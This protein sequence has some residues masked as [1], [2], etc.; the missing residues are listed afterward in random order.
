MS[1]G[2]DGPVTVLA[3]SLPLETG[4]A[5]THILPGGVNTP[6]TGIPSPAWHGADT[7]NV[8]LE[9]FII[10]ANDTPATVRTEVVLMN[11]RN[12]QPLVVGGDLFDFYFT[13]N[14]AKRS[15]G[16]LTVVVSPN[17]DDGPTRD[18]W[19]MRNSVLELLAVLAPRGRGQVVVSEATVP[20]ASTVPFPFTFDPLPNM[21]VLEGNVGDNQ[22]N[23][24]V[25]K[26]DSQRN[27]FIGSHGLIQVPLG[28]RP[29][30]DDGGFHAAAG[31]AA[32]GALIDG[33]IPRDS[34]GLPTG[35]YAEDPASFVGG[36]PPECNTML[37]ED[38][39]SG[40]A[41]QYAAGS[42]ELGIVVPTDAR[43]TAVRISSSSSMFRRGQSN[44][45][46]GP[47]D[48]LTEVDL[49]KVGIGATFGSLSFGQVLE[50]RLSKQEVL[51]SLC[52]QALFS[53]CT[54]RSR[55]GLVYE[56]A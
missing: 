4:W 40:L 43:L 21:F 47:L 28:G 46:T 11:E 38:D 36:V 45:L 55:L 17:D 12:M 33:G 9:D 15:L 52:A 2:I 18:G 27:F 3:S 26:T 51:T 56:A 8:L 41:I 29:F 5:V 1:N 23:W 13:L 44:E 7:V 6:F 35:A 32:L 42:G 50:P 19:I 54:P 14:P 37:D 49:L 22:V 16:T 53:N 25:D 34:N 48:Q 24:H 39:T 30:L 10:P 31:S 20:L